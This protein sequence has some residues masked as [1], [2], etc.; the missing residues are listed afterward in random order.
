M[1]AAL[2]AY[3]HHGDGADGV[4]PWKVITHRIL[5]S[6]ATLC[7]YPEDGSEPDL[8]EEALR[9]FALGMSAS[10]EAKRRDIKAFLIEQGYLSEAKFDNVAFGEDEFLS[11]HTILSFADVQEAKLALLEGEHVIIKESDYHSQILTLSIAR[12]DN[13][14]FLRI[15]DKLELCRNTAFTLGDSK[16][17]YT[18]NF[19]VMREGAGYLVGQAQALQAYLRGTDRD[20]LVCYSQSTLDKNAARNIKLHRSAPQDASRTG[21]PRTDRHIS[22]DEYELSVSPF[23]PDYAVVSPQMSGSDDPYY[24]VKET[25]L[26]MAVKMVKARDVYGLCDNGL[27]VNHQDSG[28]RTALHHAAFLGARACVMALLLW[29]KIDVSIKDHDGY[30]AADLAIIGADDAALSRLLYRKMKQSI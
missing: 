28:G 17:T 24:L 29:E 20:D 12:H 19:T 5:M 26:L 22:Y 23:K 6:R 25:A 9:R 21:I 18:D 30:S 15:S 10:A 2:L 11:L 16:K 13:G 4:L 7:V 3:Y 14:Q 1:R 27:N 8:K